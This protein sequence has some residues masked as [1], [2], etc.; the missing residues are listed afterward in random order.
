MDIRELIIKAFERT[1]P[2]LANA[3]KDLRPEEIKWR[4]G[5][6]TNP[7]GFI[8]WHVSRGEDS[9]VNKRIRQAPQVW[10][11]EQ[12]RKRLNFSGNPADTGNSY[13][14]EQVAAFSIPALEDLLAYNQAVRVRTMEYL[15]SM[16]PDDLDKTVDFV[17][18]TFTVGD[19]LVLYL[20]EVN[21]HIGQIDFIRGLAI[22]QRRPG[23]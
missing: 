7:I 8:L 17:G 12:W 13:T 6:L 5:P 19:L 4:P 9:F 21:H 20:G 1:T 2:A 14:S 22:S 15:K 23:G 11:D 16:A 10:D 18:R 3:V